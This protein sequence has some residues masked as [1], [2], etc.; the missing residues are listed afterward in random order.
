MCRI[1]EWVSLTV[2]KDHGPNTLNH[3][4]ASDQPMG[5]LLRIDAAAINHQLT[6]RPSRITNALAGRQ[7]DVDLF[8]RHRRELRNCPTRT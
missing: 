3:R 4:Q 2:K 1:G 5:G 7:G 8:F 6:V